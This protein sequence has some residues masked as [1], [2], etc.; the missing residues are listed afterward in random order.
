MTRKVFYQDDKPISAGGVLFLK[1]LDGHREVLIQKE[2]YISD[3]GGKVE[4]RDEDIYH[5][6]S[7]ELLEELNYGILKMEDEP[8]YLDIND[9]KELIKEN[10]IKEVYVKRCKYLLVI[11]DIPEEIIFDQELI[12]TKEDKDDI[13][14]TVEWMSID[15]FF[16]HRKELNPR[17]WGREIK[18]TINPTVLDKNP[19]TAKN[20]PL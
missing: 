10:T 14:R 15:N 20:H 2:K 18:D 17:L 4:H 1:N 3:F 7:R 11:V 16:Q 6:I 12:G 5:T 8:E 19:F 9:I 13:P